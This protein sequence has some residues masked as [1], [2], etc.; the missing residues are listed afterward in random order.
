MRLLKPHGLTATPRGT[1]GITSAVYDNVAGILTVTT[2]NA[3]NW[4]KSVEG[5]EFDGLTFNPSIAGILKE[6][7]IYP[8]NEIINPT[9]ISVYVGTSLTATNVDDLGTVTRYNRNDIKL[10]DLQFDCPPYGNEL[11]V[12]DFIYDNKTGNSL[13]TVDAEPRS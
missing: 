13:I 9:E 12:I 8:I 4:N 6:D 11:E 5:A 2:A 10:V 7:Y 3:Q 1:A